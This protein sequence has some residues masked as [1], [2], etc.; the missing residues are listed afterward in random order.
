[1]KIKNCKDC[2]IEIT[3][4]NFKNTTQRC[5]LCRNIRKKQQAKKHRNKYPNKNREIHF[6]RRYGIGLAE[7]NMM[8]QKQNGNCLICKQSKNKLFIDHCHVTGKVRGL[9]CG[10]CNSGIGFLKDS[11]NIIAD[12]LIYVM[13][14]HYNKHEFL[15]TI[16]K[17][18]ATVDPYRYMLNSEKS[19]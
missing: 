18:M 13:K 2:Q 1:M 10:V 12:A 7:Y 15:F 17:L 6:H 14:H 3:V 5:L 19:L 11:P 4:P 16:G 9:I 8:F